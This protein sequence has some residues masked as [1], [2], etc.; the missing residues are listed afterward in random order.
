MHKAAFFVHDFYG[1]TVLV[2]QG[3]TVEVSRLHSDTTFGKTPGTRR[4]DLYLTTHT[5]L[6][7]RHIHAP[8]GIRTRNPS[9][10]TAAD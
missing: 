1:W 3:L 8:G 6:N 10:R 4:R 7:N 2:G 5:V 9:K